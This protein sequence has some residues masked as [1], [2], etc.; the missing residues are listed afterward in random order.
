[1]H[2]GSE[3]PSHFS[4]SK[5]ASANTGLLLISGLQPEDEADYYCDMWLDSPKAHPVLHTHEEV[6]CK[7]PSTLLA[8]CHRQGS[9]SDQVCFREQLL[10]SLF[11]CQ[12]LNFPR[13]LDLTISHS[14]LHFRIKMNPLL[15]YSHPVSVSTTVRLCS[16]TNSSRWRNWMSP[17]KAE[18]GWALLRGGGTRDASA[19]RAPTW[20]LRYNT[21][22]KP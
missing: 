9:D 1:M 4:G 7:P 20:A 11:F 13:Q 17:R 14:F 8:L 21:R 6:R 15:V 18:S 19:L 12:H 2:Q 10:L 22:M 3:V 5:D 16:E